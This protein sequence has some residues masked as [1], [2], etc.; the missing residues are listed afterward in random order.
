MWV[1]RVYYRWRNSDSKI[2]ILRYSFSIITR[3]ASH[4]YVNVSERLHI[5][6]DNL[7]LSTQFVSFFLV[8]ICRRNFW[9][10][11]WSLKI[12]KLKVNFICFFSR[13]F[14]QRNDIKIRPVVLMELRQVNQLLLALKKL[15][16]IF[17]ENKT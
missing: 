14:Q 15:S 10:L 12:I 16:E 11:P 1:L 7:N 6:S 17:R 2:E 13:H 8:Q 9:H 3:F 4:L 5:F